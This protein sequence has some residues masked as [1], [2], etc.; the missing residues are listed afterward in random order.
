M[1]E[2]DNIIKN[3]CDGLNPKGDFEGCYN[4][5]VQVIEIIARKFYTDKEEDYIE[6]IIEE[7]C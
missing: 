4:D 6:V 1:S 7:I 5:D 3:V 2:V